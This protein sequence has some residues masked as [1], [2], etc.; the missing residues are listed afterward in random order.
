M[1]I[2]FPYKKLSWAWLGMIG[3]GYKA[4]MVV[5]CALEKVMTEKGN[6]IN[7]NVTW[8]VKFRNNKIKANQS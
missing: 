4:V 2:D 3:K 1:F 7:T 8:V 6:I 5:W